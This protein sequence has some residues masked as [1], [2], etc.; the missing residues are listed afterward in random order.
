MAVKSTPSSR[1]NPMVVVLTLPSR[2]ASRSTRR[3]RQMLDARV[4]LITLLERN[5][6]I[7]LKIMMDCGILISV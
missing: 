5:D 1:A 2:G 3:A 7:L 4:R 6:W